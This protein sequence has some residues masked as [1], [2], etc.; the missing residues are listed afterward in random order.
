MKKKPEKTEGCYMLGYSFNGGC[1]IGRNQVIDEYDAFLPS[2]A[3]LMEIT[4]VKID[5]IDGLREEIIEARPGEQ[6][7]DS[8]LIGRFCSKIV[9]AIAERIGK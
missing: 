4:L 1:I 8:L 3:E 2:M 7:T 9:D 6:L 5:E